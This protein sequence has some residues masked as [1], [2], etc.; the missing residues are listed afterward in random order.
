MLGVA[1]LQEHSSLV[2]TLDPRLAPGFWVYVNKL[3]D[4]PRTPLRTAQTAG[5]YVLALAGAILVIAS[6]FYLITVGGFPINCP[7]WQHSET[8]T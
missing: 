4:L 1:R 3:L 6:M 8:T 7:C 2:A 5:A